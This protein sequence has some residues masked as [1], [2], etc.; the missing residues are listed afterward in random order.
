MTQALV[1]DASIALKWLVREPDSDA[2]LALAR[3]RLLAPD[4]VR[5]ECGNVLWRMT[6]AGNLE[7][8]E[9]LASLAKLSDGPLM[10][11]PC[12]QLEQDALRIAIELRHPM[13]DC[14]Y[15]ALA[16]RENA[17]LVTDDRRLLRTARQHDRFHS[18]VLS[19]DDAHRIRP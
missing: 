7:E 8:G 15:L 16:E 2:A 5:T 12:G 17:P 19:L 3:F 11:T 10:F 9:A 1:I 18:L 6:V 13:Y 4:L 14:C